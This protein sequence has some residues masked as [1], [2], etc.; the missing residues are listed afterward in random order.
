MLRHD[1]SSGSCSSSS[2]SPERPRRRMA[3]KRAQG[4]VANGHDARASTRH[5]LHTH[6][7]LCNHNS[8][9]AVLSRPARVRRGLAHIRPT[10]RCPAE[11]EIC[12]IWGEA[13]SWP[14]VGQ[15]RPNLAQMWPTSA[16]IPSKVS[17]IWPD[18]GPIWP[19][20]T[21]SGQIRL[22]SGRCR[23]QVVDIGQIWPSSGRWIQLQVWPD[24][25]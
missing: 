9:P 1:P 20:S 5:A 17:P 22:K 6:T 10:V 19:S 21:A 14:E 12:P 25:V 11:V 16:R 13:R 24:S 15:H 8:G 2:A 18:S 23:A 3:R 7:R 4:D